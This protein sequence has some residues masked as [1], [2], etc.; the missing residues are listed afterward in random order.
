[1]FECQRGN[2]FDR[3]AEMDRLGCCAAVDGAAFTLAV[4]RLITSSYLVGSR[5]G[6]TSN[7]A[8]LNAA[9]VP[10]GSLSIDRGCRRRVRFSFVFP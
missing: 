2:L 9:D 1:M 7:T 10:E 8:S 5:T 3:Y 6:A 4:L